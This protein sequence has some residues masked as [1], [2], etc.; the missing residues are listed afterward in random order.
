MGLPEE[1]IEFDA[2]AAFRLRS[3]LP[4]SVIPFLGLI[5]LWVFAFVPWP[6]IPQPARREGV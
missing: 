4:L 6:S 2:S 1:S 5:G 3:S